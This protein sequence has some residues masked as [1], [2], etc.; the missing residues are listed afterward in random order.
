MKFGFKIVLGCQNIELSERVG[1]LGVGVGE[2][3]VKPNIGNARILKAYFNAFRSNQESF[4][5]G[6]F[7]IDNCE[8]AIW[9]ML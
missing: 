7:A 6:H 1:R 3:G 5:S 9:K 4:T 8:Q 2:G